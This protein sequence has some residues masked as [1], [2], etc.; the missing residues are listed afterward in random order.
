MYQ[1]ERGPFM[2][3][4]YGYPSSKVVRAVAKPGYAVGGVTV[5]AGLGIDGFSVTFME[6][7]GDALDPEKSYKSDW[8][9]GQGGGGPTPLAGDGSPV[10][11][12]FGKTSGDKVPRIGLNGFGLVTVPR[13]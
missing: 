9:G 7:K 6:I 13:K 5:K 2:G 10:V 1:A 3:R 11:G 8:L 12:I 4:Y